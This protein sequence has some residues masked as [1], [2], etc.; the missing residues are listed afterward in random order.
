MVDQEADIKEEVDKNLFK[1]KVS[2]ALGELKEKYREPFI[3][4]FF[5]QKTYEEI[6]E[7]LRVPKSTVGVLI[8]RA[9]KILKEILQKSY[10]N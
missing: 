2:R 3:L 9:K 1:E 10:V 7:I 8:L 4:Y 5:E 6:S